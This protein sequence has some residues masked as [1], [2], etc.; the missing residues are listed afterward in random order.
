MSGVR[1]LRAMFEQKGDSVPD[2]GRSPGPGG[3]ASPSPSAS[4]RPLSKVRTSFVA[5]EKDGRIGL[6]REPSRD[7]ETVSSR[8]FSNETDTSIPLPISERPDVF[9][10]NMA[11]TVASFKTNLSHEPIPESPRQETPVKFSPKKAF[12]SHPVEPNANPDKVTDKEE[13]QTKML[14][15]DP[16]ES[17][18]ARLGGTILNGGIS[19]ALN[20]TPSTA[21]KAKAP[22]ASKPAPKP[23]APVSTAKTATRP[24]K[25][26]LPTKAPSGK[27]PPKTAASAANPKKVTATKTA[28]AKPPAIDLPPSGTGFVKPKPK[29]PTRPVKLPSSLTTHTASS[30]QKHGAGNTAPAPAPRRS[31]SRASGTTS[32][33]TLKHKPSNANVGRSRPSLGPPPKPAGQEQPGSKK[34]AQVDEGF[35]ARMMRPTAS[36]AKKT[37]DKAPVTPPRKQNAPIKKL[38]TRDVEKNASKVAAKLQA[39]STQV[40]ATK[41][42]VKPAVTKEQPTP[43]VI[44]PAAQTKTAKSPIEKAK[45]STDTVEAPAVNQKAEAKIVAKEDS[46]IVAQEEV[47]DDNTESVETSTDI[48]ATPEIVLNDEPE[49]AEIQPVAEPAIATE[50]DETES[51]ASVPAV[52]EDPLKVED[53]EETVQEEQEVQEPSHQL[54]SAAPA[55]EVS[56]QNIPEVK[57]VISAE[58][59][60]VE[61]EQTADEPLG[62]E[63]TVASVETTASDE[64]KTESSTTIEISHNDATKDHIDEVA[65]KDATAVAL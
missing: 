50:V 29:S 43:K 28:A 30:A 63:E 14:S 41:N 64:A 38:D 47:A 57:D 17:S 8:R 24:P 6:R 10:E 48:P 1:N 31:L 32:T 62:S 12:K 16:T 4:P 15:G 22:G 60:V 33:K 37:S 42:G 23:A 45:L 51:A 9:S 36:S 35:L 40:K 34:E 59:P 13:P 26:P 5:I 7:S 11:S 44:V 52:S 53:I 27:E 55:V 46:A 20:G 25:S 3:F 58:E 61:V 54:E 21:V 39:S 19:D 56:E 65:I 18:A 49:A 2:R